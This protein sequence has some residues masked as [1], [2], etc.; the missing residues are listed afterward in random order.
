MQERRRGE[1][2][3][4]LAKHAP[5]VVEETLVA[6]HVAGIASL[7]LCTQMRPVPGVVEAIAVLPQ[8]AVERR[9]RQQ[10]HIVFEP[11]V[12]AREE[13][14]EAL[15]RRD[16]GGA[17]IEAEAVLLVDIGATARLV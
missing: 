16:D 10:L 6:L 8:Q 5:R 14:L 17:T 1:F 11:P 7:D 13:L 4:A 9:D 12:R 2:L 15:R 3:V